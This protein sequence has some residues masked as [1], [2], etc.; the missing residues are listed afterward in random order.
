[1]KRAA[2]DL[3]GHPAHPA[4]RQAAQPRV[5]DPLAAPEAFLEATGVSGFP[6]GIFDST[7]EFSIG[8]R[9]FIRLGASATKCLAQ[10]CSVSA[11][12]V[13]LIDH[14]HAVGH[15]AY[16]MLHTPELIP[17]GESCPVCLEPSAD[18]PVYLLKTGSSVLKPRV[19][20]K[21]LTPAASRADPNIGVK[22][23]YAGML[24]STVAMP[25]T[26]VP[27]VCPLCE[28]DLADPAHKP[29]GHP[30]CPRPSAKRQ[31]GPQL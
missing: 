14:N 28:A 7:F 1:M 21:M 10:N 5:P 13:E 25:S 24:T 16:R 29:P 12:G 20:C 9:R 6:I 22:F 3:R 8:G 27:I 26:D 18:C 19:L 30:R 23:T 17:T 4:E 15:L 2:E 31:H 11:C